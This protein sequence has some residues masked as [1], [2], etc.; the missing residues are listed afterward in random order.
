MRP[1]WEPDMCPKI[2]CLI[3]PPSYSGAVLNMAYECGNGRSNTTCL[4]ELYLPNWASRLPALTSSLKREKPALA[5]CDANVLPL[6]LNLHVPCS[7]SPHFSSIM[8]ILKTACNSTYNLA[9]MPPVMLTAFNPY[10]L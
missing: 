2:H 6:P 7:L 5:E 10:N 1:M 8:R 4:L 3:I 9:K